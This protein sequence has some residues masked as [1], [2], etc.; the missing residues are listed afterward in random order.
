MNRRSWGVWAVSTIGTFTVLEG[1]AVHTGRV[2]TLT[3]CLR[4]WLGIKPRHGRRHICRPVFGGL[5]AWF[6]LHILYGVPWPFDKG[7]WMEFHSE[8]KGASRVST[9]EGRQAR[10]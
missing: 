8:R 9:E 4:Y 10:G 2:P 7:G 1:I 5:V 6:F 3:A